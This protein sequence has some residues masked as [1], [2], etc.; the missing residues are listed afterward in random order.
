M[1]V[2]TA[3][4]KR[5]GNNRKRY[6]LRTSYRENG[7]VKKKTI[8]SLCTL[9]PEEIASLKLALKHKSDL[10]SLT[11]V[12]GAQVMQGKSYGAVFVLKAIA[13]ELGIIKALGTSKEATL[14]LWQIIGRIL[15]QGSRLSLIRAL[16][17]HEAEKLLSL[18]SGISAKQFY[19]NL[20]WLEE[21]QLK[22]EKE[23]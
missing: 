12:K 22:I 7:K 20:S 21:N 4:D 10:S 8:A 16:E 1:Y 15:F 13:K 14:A 23:N 5:N 6:L 9:K 2:D 3:I 17:V 19:N 11:S 18:P